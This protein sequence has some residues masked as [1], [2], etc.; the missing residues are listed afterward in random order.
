[1]GI[2]NRIGCDYMTN[3]VEKL[4]TEISFEI[5]KV[6]KALLFKPLLEHRKS[7]SD[8]IDELVNSDQLK[9]VWDICDGTLNVTEIAD[10]LKRNKGNISKDIKPW[11][12]NKIVFE[13]SKGKS[14]YPITIDKIIAQLILSVIE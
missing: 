7:K 14:K 11:I 1:M 6:S 2:T 9:N 4:L 3:D 13:I 12:E 5:G 8:K 10:K